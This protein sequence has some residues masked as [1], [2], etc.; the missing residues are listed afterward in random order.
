MR[1]DKNENNESSSSTDVLEARNRPCHSEI[2]LYG[3]N[4]SHRRASSDIGNNSYS[5]RI[6]SFRNRKKCDFIWYERNKLILQKLD[7][8]EDCEDWSVGMLPASCCISAFETILLAQ[9]GDLLVSQYR[10]AQTYLYE[11]EI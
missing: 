2:G 9:C 5:Q 4:L 7:D 8:C 10:Y 6:E 11:H 3:K 1:K